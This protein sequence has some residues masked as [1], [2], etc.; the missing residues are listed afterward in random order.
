MTKDLMIA[1]PS[2]ALAGLYDAPPAGTRG[3]ATARAPSADP[4]VA[5]ASDQ[6]PVPCDRSSR[7]PHSHRSN[8][9]AAR[10]R[11]L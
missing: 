3:A 10:P 11:A 6:D 4:A 1:R 8:A 5:R 7:R 2:L 9:D